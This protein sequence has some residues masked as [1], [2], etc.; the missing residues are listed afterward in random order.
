M[1]EVQKKEEVKALRA[2]INKVLELDKI[3]ELLQKNQIEFDYDGIKYRVSRPTFK[4]KAEVNEKRIEK[5]T[6]LL[7]NPNIMLEKDLIALYKKRGVDIADMTKKYEALNKTR[8][9]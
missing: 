3:T 1:E 9:D 2:R 8:E 4:H 6:A 5:Y 7:Q